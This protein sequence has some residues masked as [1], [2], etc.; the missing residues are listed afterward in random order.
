MTFRKARIT[1]KLVEGLRP[2]ETVADSALSGFMVRRQKS[3]AQVY[4]VR[5]AFRGTRHYATIGEQGANGWTEAKARQE[6]QLIIG[7]LKGGN[8]TSERV[9]AKAMPT[10]S[11]W[12]DTF[13]ANQRGFLKPA[14]IS[15]YESFARNYIAPRDDAG[16]LK[17]GCLGRLKLD[18]I[19]RA[20]VASLH[21]KLAQTPRNANHLVS[22]LSAV[23]SEAQRPDTCRK[24]GLTL[25]AT[26]S[27]IR[28]GSASAFLMRRS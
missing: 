7:I 25:R 20:E 10:L 17:P 4:F 16:H 24:P 26:S 21:R 5:K 9:R 11:E 19:T 2:G 12:L 15:N 14:T 6:A 27:A 22:F 28:N 3:D 13:L 8:P 18:H 23:F 1:T